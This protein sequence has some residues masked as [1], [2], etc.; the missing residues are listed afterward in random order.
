MER[1]RCSSSAGSSNS[2]LWDKYVAGPDLGSGEYSKVLVVRRKSDGKLFACKSTRIDPSSRDCCNAMKRVEVEVKCLS[3]MCH[4]VGVVG[5]EEMITEPG[6]WHL[7]MELCNCTLGDWIRQRGKIPEAEAA[8]VVAKLASTLADL[9]SA[10]IMHRDVKPDNILVAVAAGG[11]CCFKYADFGVSHCG[12]GLMS[13]RVGT[14]RYVAPEVLSGRY[15]FAA[16]VWSLGV[17]LYQMLAGG[18][19]FSEYSTESLLSDLKVCNIT[20]SDSLDW[21]GIP[22]GAR[23]LICKMMHKNP[24]RRPKPDDILSHPWIKEKASI[25][26]AAPVVTASCGLGSSSTSSSPLCCH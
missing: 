3:K 22:A 11:C 13:E 14:P 10:G 25:Q 6:A 1:S 17:T 2:R 23:D 19:V 16:D 5:Y 20:P 24:C 15:S 4:H 18:Q 21:S 8:A 26:I 12:T 9:H 7:V